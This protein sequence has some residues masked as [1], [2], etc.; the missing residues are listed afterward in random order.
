M[1]VK[2]RKLIVT[3]AEYMDMLYNEA[4]DSGGSADSCI[5][6]IYRYLQREAKFLHVQLDSPTIPQDVMDK[7]DEYCAD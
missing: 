5:D 4:S 6:T 3:E 2:D 7:F 1:E